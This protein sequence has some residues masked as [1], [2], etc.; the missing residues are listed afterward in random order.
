MNTRFVRALL[1]AFAIVCAALPA[2]AQRF[3]QVIVFGDSLSDAGYFRP[4]LGAAGVPASLLPTLGRFTTA[5]GPVWSELVAAYYGAP[6]GPSNVNN[7]D[8]FA[9]GGARVATNSSSTPTGAAQRPVTTQIGEYL[10]RAGGAADPNALYAVWAGANDVIQTLGALSVGAITSDQASAAIQG[11]AGAEIQQIARLQAAG[12]RYI[13]VFGL[14]NIGAT[15]GLTAAGA[16]A[17]GGATQLSAGFNLS[18]FAGLAQNNVRVIPVD[19]F[20]FLSEIRANPAAFG[21]TNISTPACGAF[22]PF[23]TSSDA[24]FCPPNVWAAPNANLTYLFADGIHPTTAAHAIIAQY[25]EAMIDGPFQYSLLAEAPLHT[26]AG[27]LRTLNDGL[28]LARNTPEG[29]RWNVFAALDRGVF[30]IDN[31]P[32]VQGL[33]DT[34]NSGSVG[35]TFNLSEAVTFGVAAGQSRSHN[36]FTRG[37]GNFNTDEK[38]VSIFGSAKLGG[39]YGTGVASISDITYGEIR[40]NITLGPSVR[41]TN[42]KTDGS[43]VS[44]SFTAG[45]DFTWRGFTIGPTAGVTT[46]HVTVSQFDEADGASS[47]LRIYEQTRRSEV[48]SFGARASLDLGGGWTPWIRATAD[49]ERRDDPRVVTA[50]PLS[51]ATGNNYDIPAYMPDTTYTTL[52]A[53][54]RGQIDQ[55]GVSAMY[56]TVLSRS[57]IRDDGVSLLLSYRF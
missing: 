18:L 32:G 33:R 9:Q 12:A 5:P 37:T 52:A 21:F 35:V 44:A 41:T 23:S 43:N 51:L 19:A 46:Q 57:G 53:G 11:A 15:P 4:V 7:G 56:V 49:K 31:E 55:L 54:I 17:S 39:F 40:R 47:N 20:S 26:R 25:V 28:T 16:T 22:P 8:I 10:A 14:P 42:A 2:Q 48:W 29:Q 38:I 50:Q 13:V 27:H 45:Y 6:T 3:S 1:G 34:A 36:Q 30:E 24:L